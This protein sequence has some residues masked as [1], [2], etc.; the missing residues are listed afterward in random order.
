[1]AKKIKKKH[2]KIVLLAKSKLNTIEVVTFK[3]LINLNISHVINISFLINNMLKEYD[4]MNKEIKKLRLKQS[5]KD[6]SLFIK[7]W[8]L[9]V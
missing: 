7:E 2:D 5:V 1:M 4:N 3:V 8:Y 6:F 9:V